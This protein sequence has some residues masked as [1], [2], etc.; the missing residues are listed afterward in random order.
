VIELSED[1]SGI[2]QKLLTKLK[3]MEAPKV[4]EFLEL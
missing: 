2:G 1:D 3:I 4:T